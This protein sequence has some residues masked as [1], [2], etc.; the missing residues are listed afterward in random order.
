MAVLRAIT[1]PIWDC[2][3]RPSYTVLR[4][5]RPSSPSYQPRQGRAK[6]SRPWCSVSFGG[7]PVW[8]PAALARRP[9]P[10]RAR[11]GL[12]TDSAL[13]SEWLIVIFARHRYMGVVRDCA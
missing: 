9:S 4:T 12:R 13:M 7:R 3:P 5:M 11:I 1:V 6:T 10:V 2:D 8:G